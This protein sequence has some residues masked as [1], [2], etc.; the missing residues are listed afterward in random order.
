[1]HPWNIRRKLLDDGVNLSLLLLTGIEPVTSS[2]QALLT[3]LLV[4]RST[5]ELKKQVEWQMR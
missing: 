3:S 4:K 1:M 5:T 2:L